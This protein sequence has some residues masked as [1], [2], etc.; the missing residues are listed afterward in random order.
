MLHEKIHEDLSPTIL[1]VEVLRTLFANSTRF[2]VYHSRFAFIPFS[3]NAVASFPY[4]DRNTDGV[5]FLAQDEIVLPSGVSTN[6]GT[7]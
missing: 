3:G 2:H 4:P 5:F 6:S 7:S 1:G